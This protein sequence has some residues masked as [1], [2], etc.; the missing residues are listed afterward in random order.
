MYPQPF[1][2]WFRAFCERVC[3]LLWFVLMVANTV[4]MGLAVELFIFGMVFA[5][6]QIPLI[7]EHSAPLLV[8][9]IFALF[10]FSFVVKLRE[11][12]V[13]YL[14]F[15]IHEG[16]LN[17]LVDPPESWSDLILTL[18]DQTAL[19]SQ[20]LVVLVQL[21]DEAPGPVERQCRRAEAK[22]WLQKNWQSL[23]EEDREFANERLSYIKISSQG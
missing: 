16:S 11:Y 5:C 3:L 19:K 1:K 22:E 13:E 18:L 12:G 15:E 4:V 14:N 17:K 9:G 7:N 23:T 2:K 20:E 21:I 10:N 8:V 6:F